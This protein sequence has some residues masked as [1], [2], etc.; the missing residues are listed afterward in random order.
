MSPDTTEPV[1]KFATRGATSDTTATDTFLS[2]AEVSQRL[3]LNKRTAQRYAA[4]LA[5]SDIR[6]ANGGFPRLVSLQAMQ[7]LQQYAGPVARHDNDTTD[8]T[9]SVATG[10]ATSDTTPNDTDTTSG[11]VAPGVAELIEELRSALYHEREETGRL[12]KALEQAQTLHLGTMGELQ[13]WQH[14]AAELEAQNAKLI[15]A[16]PVQSA[17]TGPEQ[18]TPV[19]LAGDTESDSRPVSSVDTPFAPLSVDN[20]SSQEPEVPL[21]R[22]FLDWLLRR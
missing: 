7:R 13:R 19:S 14:R 1:S 5:S 20:K 17:S 16:L 4:R 6:E 18:N 15:E 21:R 11:P 22:G 12:H 9:D 10:A 2:V 8:Q 3:G